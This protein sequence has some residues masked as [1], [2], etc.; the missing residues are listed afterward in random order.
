MHKG[1]IGAEEKLKVVKTCEGAAT[2][3]TEDVTVYKIH[4]S[5]FRSQIRNC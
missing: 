5:A 2:S 3:F 1:K 4:A